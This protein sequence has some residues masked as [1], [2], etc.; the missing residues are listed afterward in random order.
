MA[1]KA[2]RCPGKFPDIQESFKMVWRVSRWA[3]CLSN[4]IPKITLVYENFPGLHK[5]SK[6]H[7][8]L[9]CLSATAS[10]SANSNHHHREHHHLKACLLGCNSFRSSSSPS[11]SAEG[12]ATFLKRKL[13]TNQNVTSYHSFLLL[14]LFHFFGFYHLI[15]F[16]CPQDN[17]R[18]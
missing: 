13:S 11:L 2:S 12:H 15:T 5:L 9:L 16:T 6:W 18:H 14:W 17:L 10:S 3:R 7:C 1:W 8:S 4:S